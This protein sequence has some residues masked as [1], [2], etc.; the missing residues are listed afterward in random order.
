MG[1]AA[2][3]AKQNRKRDVGKW[4]KSEIRAVPAPVLVA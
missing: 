3:K 4:G 1:E 2:V